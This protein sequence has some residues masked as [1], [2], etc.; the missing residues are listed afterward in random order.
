MSNDKK[1]ETQEIEK[2]E[3]PDVTETISAT[4]VDN[5]TTDE[6]TTTETEVVVEDKNKEDIV[7]PEKDVQDV[8]VEEKSDKPED[9]EEMPEP[10]EAGS[11]TPV[12]VANYLDPSI[13][14]I[15]VVTE[16]D[17]D[18]YE[19]E[20]ISDELHDQYVDTF[21]DIREREVVTGTVVGI[22]DR[23]VLVDIGFKAEG[24]IH[25]TEFKELP[26]PGQEID[27]FIITFEDRRGNIILSK[28]RADFQKRWTEIRNCFEN[29]ELIT[30]L[31]TRRIKGGMVVDL[32]VVQAFLPGS[33]LDIKP[34]IDF[35]EFLG[36][37][38]EFKIVK[39][40]ELRQNIV[41]SRKAILEDDLL[42]KRQAVL[43][44]MEI[45]M[46][47]EGIVKNI[48]DFGAFIDLGGIDGLLHITDI[49]WGRIN[50]PTDRLAI[51][52]KINVKVIDFDVEKVRVS[53]GMKQLHPEPWEGVID[54]YPV[55]SIIEGKIVN[56]MN[57][58]A[59]IELEEG[60]EGLIHISEMSWTRHIKHPSDMF[61]VGDKIEAKILNIDSDE[62]KISLGIK[63]LQE[64]PWD[65]IES[66]FAVGSDHEG[67]VRNLTQFG[68]FIELEEG[69]DGLV[70][71]TD[72]SWTKLV[73]HPKEI[74]QK[75]DTIKV[76]ILEVSAEDRRL[77]LGIKQIEENPWENIC[78]DFSSGKVV[79]GTIIKILDKGIIFDLANNIE[80][81]V[82]LKRM[83]KHEKNQI[84]A[85]FKEGDSHEVTVQE[86]DEEYK[87]I[88]LMMD[89]GLDGVKAKE[90]PEEAVE[91]SE[92]EK[93]DIPQDIIDNVFEDNSDVESVEETE[94]SAEE[95][96]EDSEASSED[97]LD[98]DNSKD[99]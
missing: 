26:E 80:G 94:E 85:N 41:L 35:D 86:V 6:T 96:K 59:F 9:R 33:Q 51:G 89:L 12:E 23:D 47:L 13:L 1:Q 77:A 61:K 81:I 60:V 42:E 67:I 15:K 29:D 98:V 16:A 74:V 56:M 24:I 69:I 18:Q 95:S 93:I 48:T 66:K 39:L 87:K 40:N 68:A 82:P 11:P 65:T 44:E 22:T 30:G 54:K 34:V 4:E 7:S 53:L 31:I 55:D 49:T 14:D 91:V 25:R 88:I 38:S 50:H 62:K 10:E 19:E 64:N 84:V 3:T 27:V 37:E 83:Q 72:M 92:P 43:S 78:K 76:R 58:G 70:H 63:Q 36:V 71:V 32:G 20:V 75:G 2:T 79:N 99:E 57:Y 17:L 8:V 46:E 52:E 5:T 28:E 90:E 45:D 73:R 21:S 97:S